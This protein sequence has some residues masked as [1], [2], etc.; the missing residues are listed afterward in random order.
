MTGNTILTC[1]DVKKKALAF[2]KQILAI[3]FLTGSLLWAQAPSVGTTI[4]NRAVTTYFDTGSGYNMTLESNF[5]TVQ[6]L[7][8]PNISLE[9]AQTIYRP[10]G[11]KIRFSHI[12]TNTGN[13]RS[14]VRLSVRNIGNDDYDGIGLLIYDDVNGS[15]VEDPGE[16]VIAE[17]DSFWLDPGEQKYIVINGNVPVSVTAGMIAE[18]EITATQFLIGKDAITVTNLDKVIVSGG[19][20]I[21]LNKAVSE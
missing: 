21:K 20:L 8:Q 17:T 5:V 2:I 6:I 10:S 13:V 7:P 11:G 18:L 4:T 14:A 12:V 19:A 16:T 9:S 15:G 3:M 1:R